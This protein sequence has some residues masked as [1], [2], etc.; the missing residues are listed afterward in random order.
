MTVFKGCVG[1]RLRAPTAVR[2]PGY[3]GTKG[4]AGTGLELPETRPVPLLHKSTSGQGS[5]LAL[6]FGVQVSNLL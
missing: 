4:C 3:V 1:T 5:R 2:A 6:A